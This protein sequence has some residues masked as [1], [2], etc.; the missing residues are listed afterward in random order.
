[1]EEEDEH[2]YIRSKMEGNTPYL[3]ARERIEQMEVEDGGKVLS[4]AVNEFRKVSKRNS[5]L[6][7]FY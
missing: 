5:F 6:A 4:P 3:G 2:Y 1:M 7:K